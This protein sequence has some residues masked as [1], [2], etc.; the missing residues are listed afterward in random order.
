VVLQGPLIP[1]QLYEK[2]ATAAATTSSAAALT[3]AAAAANASAAADKKTEL[4]SHLKDVIDECG[5]DNTNRSA[6]ATVFAPFVVGWGQSGEEE[7]RVATVASLIKLDRVGLKST[8]KTMLDHLKD[9]AKPRPRGLYPRLE[10]VCPRRGVRVPR[11]L[12]LLVRQ[13]DS[14]AHAVSIYVR[15]ADANEVETIL[16][17]L[18]C[19]DIDSIDALTIADCIKAFLWQLQEPLIPSS[20][21]DDFARCLNNDA[22]LRSCLI[23]LPEANRDT[24]IFL[25]NHW[26]RV[27][28]HSLDNGLTTSALATVLAPFVAGFSNERVSIDVTEALLRI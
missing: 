6:V 12:T 8:L 7:R 22:D 14:R 19:V 4:E 28:T 18:G 25:L 3:S 10:D 27:L 26:Q 15:C 16:R 2:A 9:N 23:R 1:K 20:R 21:L 24:L 13:L 11:A 17:N 5:I